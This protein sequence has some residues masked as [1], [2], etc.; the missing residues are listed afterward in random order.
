MPK[1]TLYRRLAPGYNPVVAPDPNITGIPGED[2]Y[3]GDVQSFKA[4]LAILEWTKDAYELELNSSPDEVAEAVAKD[5]ITWVNAI[6]VHDDKMVR[7]VGKALELHPLTI[8]DILDTDQRTKVEHFGSYYF[9]VLKGFTGA[10][11]ELQDDHVS[12][13]FGPN[14]VASFQEKEQDVF[15]RV[16]SRI[17]QAQGRLRLRD[18]DYLA[19]AL[20]DTMVDKYLDMLDALEERIDAFEANDSAAL[21]DPKFPNL[22]HK[23]KRKLLTMRRSLVPLRAGVV[24]MLKENTLKIAPENRPFFRDLSDH[25]SQAVETVDTLRDSLSGLLAL[26]VSVVGQKT[27]EEMRVLT[28][29]AT[30]F[31]P[32]T[33]LVGVYGMNFD[34]MPELHVKWAYPVLWILMIGV[35]AGLWTHF[36]RRRWL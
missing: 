17:E 33:F 1:P 8:E 34:F 5:R 19:Y 6:G 35:A 18:H 30:I 25:L 12:I 23:E 26:H 28:V 24:T 15:A 22:L 10:G 3:Q 14:F 9:V 20:M 13:V 29:I 31:I 4:R 2:G 36:R 7:A 21:D 16:F 32:L 11:D 27:N